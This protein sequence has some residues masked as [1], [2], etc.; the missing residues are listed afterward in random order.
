MSEHAQARNKNVNGALG[1][2]EQLLDETVNK[3]QPL[4]LPADVR[5]WLGRNVWWMSLIGGI[6]S[7]WGAWTFWQVGH[8]LSTVNP[9]LDE[10]AR[11]NGTTYA[12]DLGI[13]WYVALVG[14]LVEG[15]L[16]LAAIQKLKRGAK[17]GWDLL[18]YTSLVSLVVSLVYM[19]VPGYGFG[20]LLGALVGTAIGWFFL[21][22][23]RSQFAK[24]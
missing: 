12:S 8:Y 20:S 23:I 19:F 1:G 5:K 9:Y 24:R 17:G 13:M 6:L 21:F 14:L 3:K 4:Q 18:F 10:L 11:V 15:V 2:L 7:V 16:M 22:Q